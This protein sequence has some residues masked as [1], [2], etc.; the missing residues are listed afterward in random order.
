[1][2]ASPANLPPPP[3]RIS[4][5]RRQGEG[6]G[7]GGEEGIVST[8]DATIRE[9]GIVLS[10]SPSRIASMKRRPWRKFLLYGPPGTGKSYLAEAVV[11]EA[12]SIFFSLVVLVQPILCPT[13]GFLGKLNP[14]PK[15]P[16]NFFYAINYKQ[17][18]K[19]LRR[20]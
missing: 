16:I 14:V 5:Q 7:D 1:M 17:G 12:D 4:N 20:N 6:D 18:H 15:C 3:N 9:V 10:T 8:A 2:P 19:T 13:N 11:T